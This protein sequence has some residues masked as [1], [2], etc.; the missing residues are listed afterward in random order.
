MFEVRD[1][2]GDPVK[3]V[4][5]S[6]YDPRSIS[7][8]SATVLGDEHGRCELRVTDESTL[9]FRAAGFAT[10]DLDDPLL[11]P[12]IVVLPPEARVAGTVR[13]ESGGAVPGAAVKVVETL[14]SGGETTTDAQGRFAYG[15]LNA[16]EGA[17]IEVEASGFADGVVMARSNDEQVTVVLRALRSVSGVVVDAQGEP[18]PGAAVLFPDG[19]L[20]ATDARGKFHGEGA[21]PDP[22]YLEV[23]AEPR[24]L[25][26]T[27]LVPSDVD[28]AEIVARPF[29]ASYARVRLVDPEADPSE[30]PLVAGAPTTRWLPDGSLQVLSHEPPGTEVELRVERTFA[31]T[32]FRVRTHATE[33]CDEQVVALPAFPRV[34]VVVRLPDGSPLPADLEADIRCRSWPFR[35]LERAR[36]HDRATFRLARDE[37]LTFTVEVK[38][39]PPVSRHAALPSDDTPVTVRLSEGVTL[40]G[41]L[42]DESGEP[43]GQCHVSG[44]ATGSGGSATT[45]TVSGDGRFELGPLP[46]EEIVVFA[47]REGDIVQAHARRSP[48]STDLGTMKLDPLRAVRGNVFGPDG[49]P[50]AGV[51]VRV[52]GGAGR[53]F[54]PPTATRTD[55]AFATS[56]AEWERG[57][58][59]ALKPGYGA[60][61]AP[62]DADPLVLRM[63]HAGALLLR[64]PAG[65]SAPRLTAS[66]ANGD[67]SWEPRGNDVDA[68]TTRYEGLPPGP[69]DLKLRDADGGERSLRATIVAGETV[70]A[71]LGAR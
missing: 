57:F 19:T 21:S 62:L 41:R 11:R 30:R 1:A 15:G 37:G 6:Q 10:W 35:E 34:T 29:P 3:R 56:A 7:W 63:P 28:R 12:G 31:W 70:E 66:P 67:W 49:E 26:A 68:T 8:P 52:L 22:F 65:T 45:W 36:A 47:G 17:R 43:P 58:V 42:V 16:G 44:I 51:E 32:P 59:L 55:G 50:V 13:D 20:V 69:L 54:Y 61:A 71:D 60:Q 23:S 39:Y 14:G 48:G 24:G 40:H 18:V 2:W 33:E 25:A 4:T 5:V 46:D 9:R 27:V 53:W 38:G 64:R